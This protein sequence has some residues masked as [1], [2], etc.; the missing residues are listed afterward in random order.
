[1][2]IS[3]TN[4]WRGSNF[5]SDYYKATDNASDTVY[6]PLCNF[7]AFQ[8]GFIKPLHRPSTL[9]LAIRPL[10][11]FGFITKYLKTTKPLKD[12]SDPYRTNKKLKN[13]INKSLENPV[14]P[15]LPKKSTKGDE[16]TDK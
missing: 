12:S 11:D 10:Q 5:S 6:I 1:M 13:L 14:N 15:V 8:V 2:N 16:G 4:T 3:Y 7:S 9:T